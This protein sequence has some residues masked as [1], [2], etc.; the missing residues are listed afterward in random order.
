MDAHAETLMFLPGASGDTQFWRPLAARLES[1]ANQRFVG[2]P[3]FGGVPPDRN[4]QG[5]ADLAA[6]VASEI[7][8]PV[9]VFAQSMGG[10]V[11]ML[12]ALEKPSLVK[13]LVLTV[14]SGGVDLSRFGALDWRAEFRQRNPALPA[15]FENERWDLAPRL[16]ELHVP[17]LLLW[18]DADP[19]SPVG[20]G[21]TL[22]ELL[23]NAELVVLPGGTHDLARERVDD[24]LPHVEKHL[25]YRA[26]TP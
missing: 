3:G 6:G 1:Q 5:L 25:G 12:V 13:R 7:S 15:W 14:T 11:A 16:K 8:G 2:W 19:I 20:V 21:R 24:I 23:P 9:N 22:A 18:G 4:V 26:A 10:V 17:T